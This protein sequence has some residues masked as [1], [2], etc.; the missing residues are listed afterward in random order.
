MIHRLAFVQYL[1]TLG[2]PQSSRAGLAGAASLLTFHDAVEMLLVLGLQHHDRYR[3]NKQYG[4]HDYWTEL[5]EVGVAVI[6]RGTMEAMKDSRRARVTDMVEWL[7]AR[8]EER[9]RDGT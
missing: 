3:V 4:F 5:A 2:L 7:K 9:Q 1:Y 6:Q 8:L